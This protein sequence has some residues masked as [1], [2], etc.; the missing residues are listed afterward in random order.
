MRTLIVDRIFEQIAAKLPKVSE[1][2]GDEFC[3]DEDHTEI[4]G[5]DESG[6]E[7]IAKLFDQLYGEGTVITGYYD[8]DE[9]DRMGE[10]DEFTGLYYVSIA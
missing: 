8:P 5:V 3:S 1:R 10:R 4:L 9:D 6:I 2:E 7:T